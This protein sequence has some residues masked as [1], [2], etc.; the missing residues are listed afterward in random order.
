MKRYQLQEAPAP[1]SHREE[2]SG[3][4]SRS[5]VNRFRPFNRRAGLSDSPV[6]GLI[7][8]I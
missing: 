1:P 7:T 8:G 2:D 3:G 6:L 4:R 5:P